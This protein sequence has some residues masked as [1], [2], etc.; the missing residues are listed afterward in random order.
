MMAAIL[1]TPVCLSDP[2]LAV[3][4]SESLSRFNA[5]AMSMYRSASQSR[6]ALDRLE[7]E[8]DD[9]AQG[10]STGPD[11]PAKI[12]KALIDTELEID[13]F[14][15]VLELQYPLPDFVDPS[16]AALAAEIKDSVQSFD[17]LLGR[18]AA[19]GR[20]LLESAMSGDVAAY[21]GA[22][23]KSLRLSTDFVAAESAML[24]AA[25]K[26]LPATDPGYGLTGAAIE[27]N[28][29]AVIMWTMFAALHGTAEPDEGSAD[30]LVI[31]PLERMEKALNRADDALASSQS[32][33][34]N[35]LGPLGKDTWASRP[36]AASQQARA[37]SIAS[38]TRSAEIERSILANY[39]KMRA[40]V[41]GKTEDPDAVSD[42][43]LAQSFLGIVKANEALVQR[44]L[45]EAATH[46]N[47]VEAYGQ[48]ALP[49]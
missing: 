14:S 49:E 31:E 42:G 9:Y 45:E 17:D 18:K 6:E 41:L 4:D 44:R 39:R 29:A 24:R 30:T 13:N 21:A 37:D 12:E 48:T 5:Q 28:D 16:Y 20:Q 36:D 11:I 1:L 19:I 46:R 47:I 43:A 26:L 35:P 40:M 25:L 3:S 34:E 27:L 38:F 15:A 32:S 7:R 33:L 2:A 8:I 22:S 23:I 10:R